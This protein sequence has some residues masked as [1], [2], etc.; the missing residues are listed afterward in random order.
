MWPLRDHRA[1]NTA[2]SPAA[3]IAEVRPYEATGLL[4]ASRAAYGAACSQVYASMVGYIVVGNS[5][6]GD[7][8]RPRRVTT[9]TI[10]HD[11]VESGEIELGVWTSRLKHVSRAAGSGVASLAIE[12]E[13]RLPERGSPRSHFTDVATLLAAEAASRV[14]SVVETPTSRAL[15]GS[16]SAVPRNSI[17]APS[18]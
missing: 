6:R 13:P 16:S 4:P 17:G 2:T 9:P 15:A 12:L 18:G 1:D 7:R 11:R 10:T 3:R 14:R 5:G 8:A